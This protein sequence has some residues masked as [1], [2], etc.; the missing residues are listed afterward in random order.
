MELSGE[1]R[2]LRESVAG[3]LS[4]HR[5]GRE[6]SA[7]RELWRLL[8]GI[9]VAGLA[10]PERYGGAGASP[11]ETSIVAEELGRVLAP[12]PLLSAVLT[13]AVILASGDDGA[14]E[15]LLP[16]IA[17]GAVIAALAWTGA[18]GSWDPGLAS[19][20]A[21]PVP[22]GGAGGWALTGTAHY[23]LDGDLAD[24]LI[25]AATTPEN[26]EIGLFEVD[27]AQPGVSRQAVPSMDQT[28][29]L[30]VIELAGAAGRRI[31]SGGTGGTGGPGSGTSALARARDLACVALSAEQVGAAA[32]A[33]DLTVAYTK[34]RIQFGRPIA[35]FQAIQHRLAELHVLVESARALS[36]RAASAA[37]PD[38][39][40]LAAA[41]RSYCSDVLTEVTAETIQL[42]GAIAITWEHE[43]HRDFKR[44]HGSARL[45]GAPAAHRARI[46]DSLL[47]AP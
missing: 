13:A 39:A 24:V 19:C 17:S 16:P 36:Y 45:F 38:L 21:V 46:A 44:A 5:P 27:P 42:H 4:R 11:A 10:I 47:D 2:A 34:T 23:V 9:G 14:C 40:L 33:L 41:A 31:G 6:V 8:A 20:Q 43:A 1:Q 22:D 37:G 26:D 3:L 30:S 28:R 35:S 29:R 7:D 12:A 32:A 15:R 25:V 18:E